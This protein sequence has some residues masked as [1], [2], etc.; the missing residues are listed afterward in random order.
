MAVITFSSA[1]RRALEGI[2]VRPRDR[3]HYRRAQALLWR[4]EGERPT[5]SLS[6]CVGIALPSMHGPSVIRGV[7]LSPSRRAG[8]IA[9]ALA[10]RGTW[11]RW[12]RRA[13]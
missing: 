6:D 7:G 1:G 8:W 4:A 5:Q 2:V 3:R 10:V 11:L 12:S 13:W 9:H